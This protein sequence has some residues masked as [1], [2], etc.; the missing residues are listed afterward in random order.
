MTAKITHAEP[1][2]SI[3]VLRGTTDNGM[4]IM[5]AAEWRMAADI[6]AALDDGEDVEV[7]FEGWQVIG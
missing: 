3:G 5:L 7:E 2:G 6:A 4:P 1:Q